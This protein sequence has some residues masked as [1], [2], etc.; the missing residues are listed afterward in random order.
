MR[1]HDATALVTGASSGIGREFATTLAAR[2]ANLVLAGR[3]VDRLDTLAR[4]LHESH[5][6]TVTVLE[7]DFSRPRA[8]STL[9]EKV[10][11]RGIAISILVNSAG[12]GATGAFADS[13][14]ESINEQIAVNVTALSE[15]TREFLPDV[16]ATGQGAIVNVASLTG[17]Q[18]TPNMAVYAAT[19]A[20]VLSFTE[21]LAYELR[22]APVRVLALS[23]GPT[24]TEF[25]ATS[26]TSE[27]GA[28]F[29]TPDQVV[30]A[31]LRALD[32]S[33]TPVQVV[34]GT[35][36]RLNL[37]ILRRLPRRTAL[38]IMANATQ[39]V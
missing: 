34:S 32:A 20:Y 26:H 37:A 13:G 2:R 16:L 28:R 1:Y 22:H 12:L 18:P 27:K 21:A 17:H 36:N 11:R 5:G 35:R 10:T 25:Y 8:A 39:T 4:R 9:H 7:A 29:Q 38:K 30:T 23:P 31:G 15:V 24:R 33:R 19:K 3:R 6:V 14:I